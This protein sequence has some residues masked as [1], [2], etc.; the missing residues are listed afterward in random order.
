VALRFGILGAGISGLVL[1]TRL[2]EA[3]HEVVVL[4]KGRGVG[5]RTSI[6]RVD[7]RTFDHGAQY[8]TA[9]DP[10]FRAFLDAHVP[11]DCHAPW[12]ARF[13]VLEGGRLVEETPWTT[14]YVGVPD[15]N[16]VARALAGRL[17]VRSGARVE[18]LAGTEGRWDLVDD[19]GTSHGPFDWVVATAPA[20]QSA[21]ILRGRSP[22]ATELDRV[23]MRPC[24][25]LMLAP[26]SGAAFPAD[27]IRCKHSVLGWVANDGSKPGR[28]PG[29]SLVIHSSHDWADAHRDDDPASVSTALKDAAA[30]AFGLDLGAVVAE[31]LHRWLYAAP[32]E[33]LG[34]PC[35][36]D[37]LAR[38]AACGDWCVASKVEGAFLSGDACARAILGGPS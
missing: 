17:E 19:A 3:G 7:G 11:P 30:G 6:R 2:R 31:S 9:R 34:V 16:A 12:D 5:G 14:R 27:G 22:I 24:D 36:V 29:P 1:A 18:A 15:M 4:D 38:L 33:P 32:A 13:A 23:A 28:G 25:A 10:A 8:F 26:A 20:P 21:A 35:L 37:G